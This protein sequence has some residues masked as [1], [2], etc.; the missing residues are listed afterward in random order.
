[1]SPSVE[2]TP[3]ISVAVSGDR[4]QACLCIA[5]N[6]RPTEIDRDEI[7]DAIKDA[8]LA[9]T[10]AITARIDALMADLQKA[11]ACPAEVLIA[12]GRAPVRGHGGRFELHEAVARPDAEASVDEHDAIDYRDFRKIVTVAAGTPIGR[13][14]P[15][16]S[17]SNGVD[18][19]GNPIEPQQPEPGPELDRATVTE[20]EEDSELIVSKVAGKIACGNGTISID[21][22]I[23]IEGDV[24][25]DTGNIEA[26]VDV[27]I[28]GTVLDEF[29]VTCER[30]INIR[31]AVQAAQVT[32]K[33]DINIRGG[34]LGRGRGRVRA[35]GQ[36]QVKFAQEATLIAKDDLFIK[37]EAMNS[38]I[39]TDGRLIAT[40]GA[41]IGG[42][43]Y[44]RQGAEI[45]TIGSDADIASTIII[46]VHPAVLAASDRIIQ[47]NKDKAK[48]ISQIRNAVQPL[49]ANLKR[50]TAEQKERAT[51]LLFT[52]DEMQA[53]V[54]ESEAR[55]VEML[56]ASR[57]PSEPSIL[58]SKI[59][60]ANS[61]IRI[62]HRHLLFRDVLKG[63][64][65]I[66]RRK[67]KNVTE[68]V[69][70]NQCSGSITVLRSEEIVGD[71]DL[72]L[73]DPA[74]EASE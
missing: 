11:Q 30:S 57:P 53:G 27:N 17:G 74:Q 5:G 39:H 15:P 33:G 31:G 25:F 6:V 14:S 38:N 48:A 35:D 40:H 63:P 2:T 36:L 54:D 59:V 8:R 21:E 28:R 18:V 23:D 1:M 68:F 73:I 69:A 41:V 20:S 22:V 46:G 67:I 52:A 66:E 55:R 50:L 26:A 56:K 70:V 37:K 16:Q 58:I 65:R 62:G 3:K 64:V 19:L 13:L 49:M 12:E 24:C 43:C 47:E 9:L 45:G 44:A 4:M 10:D 60:N 42:K 61:R 7:L 71:Q 29:K 72:D 32:A 34:I 51:E